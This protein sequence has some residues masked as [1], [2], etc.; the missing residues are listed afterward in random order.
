MKFVI[1]LYGSRWKGLVLDTY[2]IQTSFLKKYKGIG[3]RVLILK[4][5]NGNTSRKRIIKSMNKDWFKE[6]TPFSISNINPDWLK[7]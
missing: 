4:D 3:Y 5:K 6:I 7:M 1:S 2:S